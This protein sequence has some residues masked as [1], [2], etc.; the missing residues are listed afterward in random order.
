MFS[1]IFEH[2]A[3][4]LYRQQLF[5]LMA[6]PNLVFVRKGMNGL[7][8]QMLVHHGKK[9]SYFYLNFFHYKAR[10]ASDNSLYVLRKYFYIWADG[11]I[12]VSL[13]L[14]NRF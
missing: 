14:I 1:K 3:L 11:I 9:C 12:M 13:G 6:S 5:L 8:N 7:W 2:N 10:H 4:T